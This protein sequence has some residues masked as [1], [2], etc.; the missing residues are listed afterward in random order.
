MDNGMEILL[1]AA[2]ERQLHRWAPPLVIIAT[3]IVMMP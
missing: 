3:V 1:G 2:K